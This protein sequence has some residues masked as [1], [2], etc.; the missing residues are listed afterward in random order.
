MNE[1]EIM[2]D[3]PPFLTRQEFLKGWMILTT[4]PWGKTYRATTVRAGEPPSPDSLQSEFYYRAFTQTTPEIW[5]RACQSVACGEYWPSIDTLRQAVKNLTP[6]DNRVP[7][8]PSLRI[9]NSVS[10]EEALQEKPEL[11]ETLK[12]ILA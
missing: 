3:R 10:M 2:L 5:H 6:A 1:R 9:D 8:P 7:L 11:L 12:R 4:Q